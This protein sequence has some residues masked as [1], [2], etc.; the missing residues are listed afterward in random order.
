M[1]YESVRTE[2]GGIDGTRREVQEMHVAPV[3]RPIFL[4]SGTE[5]APSSRATS[6]QRSIVQLQESIIQ[7]MKLQNPLVKI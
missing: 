4:A 7:E 5:N 3:R 1:R 6:A 2:D